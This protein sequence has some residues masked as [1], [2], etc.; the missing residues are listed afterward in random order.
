MNPNEFTNVPKQ[1]QTKSQKVHYYEE[2]WAQFPFAVL[3]TTYLE[4]EKEVTDFEIILADSL[5]SNKKFVSLMEAESYIASK[6]YDLIVTL[7]YQSLKQMYEYE[8]RKEET[9][10]GS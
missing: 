7:I 8:Q 1:E 10:T 2:S 6:P 3:E 9:N 4:D 5:A